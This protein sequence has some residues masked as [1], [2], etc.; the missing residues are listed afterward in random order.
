MHDM[1]A[2]KFAALAVAEQISAGANQ[3]GVDISAL[4]GTIAVKLNAVN[5]SGTSPT[6]DVH[7]E[8][9][10]DNST[11]SDVT[12]GAFTQVTDAAAADQVLYLD[13]R[14]LKKYLRVVDAV[15]GT[16]P[17]FDRSVDYVGQQHVGGA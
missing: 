13:S 9:S 8:E 10:A 7:L 2:N 16:S 5:V 17:V 1:R 3:S 14:G 15:G 4:I 6:L 11:W 12:G